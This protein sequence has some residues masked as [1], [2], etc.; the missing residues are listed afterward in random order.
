MPSDIELPFNVMHLTAHHLESDHATLASLSLVSRYWHSGVS[1]LVFRKVTIAIGDS[2]TGVKHVNGSWSEDMLLENNLTE[3]GVAMPSRPSLKPNLMEDKS[4]VDDDD[5]D[6]DYVPSARAPQ[7]LNRFLYYIYETSIAGGILDLTIRAHKTTRRRETG[8]E[9]VEFQPWITATEFVQLLGCLPKLRS[10]RLIDIIIDPDYDANEILRRYGPGE[11]DTLLVEY[12][13]AMQLSVSELI[14]P[15]TLL[16][17]AGEVEL[18]GFRC[19]EG[20]EATPNPVICDMNT[21]RLVGT[22]ISP[23]L[24]ALTSNARNNLR[25]IKTIHLGRLVPSDVPTLRH[26]MASP[27]MSIEVQSLTLDFDFAHHTLEHC[28]S[29]HRFL[30]PRAASRN[31]NQ[32]P[33]STR[34]WETCSRA[35]PCVM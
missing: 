26:V 22:N 29:F 1:S 14:G 34:T 16:C 25:L 2:N 21:L 9:V 30:C 15:L 11:L 18:R 4:D 10:L 32:M 13:G 33:H 12:T 23:V 31:C 5:F 7:S 17:M 35:P 6:P 8:T 19:Q 27:E 24:W 3:G 20:Y 28:E